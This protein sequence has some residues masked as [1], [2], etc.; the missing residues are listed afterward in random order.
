V[1]PFIIFAVG[2][3]AV[4]IQAVAIQ[5]TP[6]QEIPETDESPRVFFSYIKGVFF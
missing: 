4:G 1:L 5:A 6:Q 2:I 3:Q